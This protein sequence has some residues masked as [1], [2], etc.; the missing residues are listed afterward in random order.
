VSVANGLEALDFLRA[1]S[2]PSVILL[3]LMMPGMN[4]SEFR[5]RQVKDPRLAPIPTI[6][7]T[8]VDQGW[9]GTGLF[10]SCHALRKPLDLELLLTTVLS[11]E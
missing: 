6:V 11:V 1:H 2:L 4:G 10:A 3:D 7:L 5:S 9:Q 8:A